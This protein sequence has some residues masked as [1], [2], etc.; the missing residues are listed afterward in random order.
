MQLESIRA[1]FYGRSGQLMQET[2]RPYQ[3]N[4]GQAVTAVTAVENGSLR[5][6]GQQDYDKAVKAY[7]KLGYTHQD[8]YADS[9][10]SPNDKQRQGLYEKLSPDQKKSYG[11]ALQKAGLNGGDIDAQSIKDHVFNSGR[12]RRETVWNVSG[13]PVVDSLMTRV[14][15]TFYKGNMTSFDA[16]R[17][18]NLRGDPERFKA[19]CQKNLPQPKEAAGSGAWL[20]AGNDKIAAAPPRN[21]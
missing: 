9:T 20:K 10:R 13:R 4:D 16:E 12:K 8:V 6:V 17:L 3:R 5:L 15:I 21:G 14:A 2:F 11:A 7:N 1:E 18:D 19:F